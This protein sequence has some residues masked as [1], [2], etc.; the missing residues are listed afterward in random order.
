[1]ALYKVTWCMVVWCT[2]NLRRDSCSF[3]WHK[4]C[5]R[6]KYTTSVDI[7]KTRYEKLVSHVEPQRRIALYK[8]S[9]IFNPKTIKSLS[10][11]YYS[12]LSMKKFISQTF[13]SCYY[14]LSRIS[15]LRKYLSTEATVKLVTSFILSRLDYCNFLL[16]GL[17]AC[18]LCP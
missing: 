15:S 17:V 7:Q 5:Q 8:R 14:Q 16:S 3:M 6:C 18:F 10:V 12:T 13:K 1:M 9:S 4:P 11:I 2:Q